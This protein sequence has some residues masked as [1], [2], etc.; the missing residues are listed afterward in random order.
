MSLQFFSDGISHYH[1]DH[2]DS[3][4]LIGFGADLLKMKIF[5]SWMKYNQ[6]WRKFK[7][8]SPL[9]ESMSTWHRD[10]VSMA[11]HQGINHLFEEPLRR[12]DFQSRFICSVT[13]VLGAF[14]FFD[15]QSPHKLTVTSYCSASSETSGNLVKGGKCWMSSELLK[16]NISMASSV[17]SL[18]PVVIL[19]TLALSVGG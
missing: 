17:C 18:W 5:F 8:H 15:L 1:I 6:G 3:L 12:Q 10:L 14:T 9:L 4:V 2:I 16:E 13:P 19:L 7:T 11:T